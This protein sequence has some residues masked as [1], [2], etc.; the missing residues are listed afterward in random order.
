MAGN[1]RAV[2]TRPGLGGLIAVVQEG[3]DEEE[4]DIED[5]EHGVAPMWANLPVCWVVD[6]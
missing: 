3:G 4:Q 6:T 5:T 2:L 1:T